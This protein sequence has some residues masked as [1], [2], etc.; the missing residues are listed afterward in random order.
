MGTT[1]HAEGSSCTTIPSKH[2]ESTETRYDDWVGLHTAQ[3]H[4]ERGAISSFGEAL[5]A[6]PRMSHNITTRDAG[7]FSVES[8]D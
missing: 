5:F 3:Q 6:K 2:T 7:G 1:T 4:V 8:S